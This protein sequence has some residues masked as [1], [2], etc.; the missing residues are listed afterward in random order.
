MLLLHGRAEE[1]EGGRRERQHLA[2]GASF[3][4]TSASAGRGDH[5]RRAFR[6]RSTVTST[7]LHLIPERFVRRDVVTRGVEEDVVTHATTRATVP[8]GT[9]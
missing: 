2:G 4:E 9:F 6:A 1:H 8:S 7:A 5:T 3:A